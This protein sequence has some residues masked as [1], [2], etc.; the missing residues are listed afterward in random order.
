MGLIPTC[1]AHHA[2]P[3]ADPS[4]AC[5][6]LTCGVPASSGFPSAH[7]CLVTGAWAQ[8]ARGKTPLPRAAPILLGAI[9]PP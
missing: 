5:I 4:R 2:G 8:D 6:T 9:L 7:G 3:A 1:M